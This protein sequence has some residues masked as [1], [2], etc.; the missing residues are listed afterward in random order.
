MNA[1]TQARILAVVGLATMALFGVAGCKNSETPAAKCECPNGTIHEAGE[2]CCDGVDCTCK[3]WQVRT[4]PNVNGHTVTIEDKTGVSDKLD[5]IENAI[6]SKLSS[7]V[8]NDIKIIVESGNPYDGIVNP[9]KN[10]YAMHIDWL[11]RT[12]A[13]AAYLVNAF[14][15]HP[16]ITTANAFNSNIRLA[17]GASAEA[18]VS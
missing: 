2:A 18:P 6:I 4:L 5:V 17:N 3:E 1:L 11:S 16:V 14:I 7:Y 10:T 8:T 9:S 12:D 13:I 15:D